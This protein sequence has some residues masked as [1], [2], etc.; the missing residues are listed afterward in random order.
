MKNSLTRLASCLTILLSFTLPRY[1]AMYAQAPAERPNIIWLV[2]EDNSTDYLR[3]YSEGGAAMPHVEKLAEQGIVFNHA[4]SQAPVCSAARSTIIS[5]C[6]GPRIGAQYHRKMQPAPMP[7][8]LE[9]F[10]VYLRKAG[11]YTTNNSKEDYNLIK[12]EEVWDNSSNKATYRDRREGQP[13]FHVQNFGITHEGQLHFSEKEM[14]STPTAISPDAMTPFPYH[15]NTPLFRYTNA[16]YR[17]LHAKADEAIGNFISQLEED[18]LMENTIIFYYGDHGGVL[19]GSKGYIYERGVHVPMVVYIPEKWKHLFPLER[20]SRTDAFVQFMDLAPTV[21]NLAGIQVPEQMDGLP[22]LGRGITREDLE[23]RK[24]TFSYADR[25]DEKYDLVRAVREGKYKYMR[26]YQPF[27]IDGLYNFYR[28]KMLAYQEWRQ[29]FIDNKLNDAQKQFFMP[30]APEALY[31]LEKD[32]YELNNLAGDPAYQTILVE[33][34]QKLQQ[35]LKSMHD[36]S[37]FPEPYFLEQGIGN[38]VK[39][40]A[41]RAKEIAEL[42]DVADLALLPFGE[43]RKGIEEALVSENPWKRYW[44]F[45]ACTI[46]GEQAAPFYKTAVKAAK[47]DNENLVR[48]RA[49]EFLALTKKTDSKPVLLE[50]LKRAKSEAEANL[51]LNTVALLKMTDPGFKMEVPEEIF[52]KEWLKSKDGLVVR[53]LEYIRDN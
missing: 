44:G 50:A 33:L 45:I 32:P 22:F 6:Y 27:N 24:T 16:R 9:M 42:M 3:L 2:T 17:D 26:S 34:R 23:G 13:F 40:G 35:Q 46:F 11:Y 43:A 7:E 12:S 28:Y 18:G 38:P 14:Q 19:P 1:Q 10:P 53:R 29:L 15:P 52:R 41:D 8:G 37:F 47:N 39:F 36:L 51:I 48:V 30:R 5:G 4:F 20:G 31:D 25:F 49:A 21:L